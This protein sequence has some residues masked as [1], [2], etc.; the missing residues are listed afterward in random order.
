MFNSRIVGMRAPQLSIVLL[1]VMVYFIRIS[2]SQVTFS[3]DWNAGKR[4]ASSEGHCF[5]NAKSTAAAFHV[6][7]NELRQLSGCEARA[8]VLSL[9]TQDDVPNDL[10]VFPEGR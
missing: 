1:L 10:A 3:R 9:R 5:A 4:T 7:T 6:L 8:M 2:S